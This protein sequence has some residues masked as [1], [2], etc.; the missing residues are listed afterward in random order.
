MKFKEWDGNALTGKWDITIKI[1]GI[2][3]RTSGKKLVSKNNKPLHHIPENERDFEIAEIFTGTWGETWSI[4]SASKSKRREIKKEE[5]FSLFPE[6]DPRLYLATEENPTSIV[7]SRWM[8]W[9]LNK[10]FEGL[11]LRQGDT[12]I[13]V[14]KVH[15]QD[16]KITGWKEGKGKFKGSLGKFT[17]GSGDCGVGFTHGQR[18]EYWKKK[19]QLLNTY[20]E[21]KSMETTKNGKLRNPRF[22]RLRPDK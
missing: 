13:K 12:F 20:I 21:V 22:V 10:G 7:I 5:I 19:K 6:L 3:A 17:T 9:V 14:K 4:V 18:K 15:T 8:R 11:V 2:Q 16:V 1:D